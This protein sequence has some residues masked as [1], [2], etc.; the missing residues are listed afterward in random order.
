MMLDQRGGHWDET[1]FICT[2]QKGNMMNLENRM[3]V[4]TLM[5]ALVGTLTAVGTVHS[6][7]GSMVERLKTWDPDNDGTLDLAEVKKAA[8]AKFDSLE[9]DKDGTLDK[10]EMRS[11][12]VDKDDFKTADPDN[13]G[14]LTKD[15]FLTIVE[16]RF[17]AADPDNDGTLSAGELKA[18]AGKSLLRLMK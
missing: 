8:E 1:L 9:G 5:L 15:E 7:Q 12:K 18:K 10:K 11:T 4:G 2:L 14:T 16:S 6:A 17:K 3:V 13:D